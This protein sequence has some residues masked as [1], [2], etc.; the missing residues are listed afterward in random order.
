[1]AANLLLLLRHGQAES[2]VDRRFTTRTDSPLTEL[3]MTQAREAAS[4]LAT[5]PIDRVICSPMRRAR[6]TGE[7]VAAA[8]VGGAPPV[9]EDERLTE[10]D[11]GPFEGLTPAEILAGP[12][13]D[14]YRR[15][16]SDREPE[17]PAGA[18]TL[19]SAVSRSRAFIELVSGLDGIT[20]ASTHGS[21]ARVM[22]TAVVLGADPARYRHMWMDNARMAVIRWEAGGPLLVGFNT[23]TLP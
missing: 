10:I 11:A 5:V 14:T 12:L 16:R 17:F 3:G 2:N 8:Q 13:A 19:D 20:L 1:M 22:V 15:W 9:T 21:L 23:L 7:L 4:A 18:E 6:A